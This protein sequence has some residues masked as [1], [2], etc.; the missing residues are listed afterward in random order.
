[1]YASNLDKLNKWEDAKNLF[2]K[3]LKKNPEDTYTLNYISYR[4][5]LRDEKLGY[6]LKL[7]K[8]ALT[9]DPENGYFLDTIG[10]VE[11]KRKNFK[12]AVFYLE[13]ATSILPNSAEVLDHLGDCYFKLG[14][15]KEAIYQWERALKYEDNNIIIKR[16]SQK[17]KENE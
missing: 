9:L 16:I 17:I 13:K 8:K 12:N 10:W 4:L 6:A 7:I 3:L 15:K 1:L 2:L 11:F 5:S 14:R